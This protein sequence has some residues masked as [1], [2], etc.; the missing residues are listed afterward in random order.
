ML[1]DAVPMEAEE[2][3][4]RYRYWLHRDLAM[5]G[6]VGLVF[7]MLNPSTADA[8]ADDPTIRRCK[9]FGRRWGFRELTVVNLFALRATRPAALV[10][11]GKA[12][13]GERNDDVLR[14]VP[15]DATV[16][17]AWGNHGAHMGRA[18]SVAALLPP[19]LALGHTKSGF[20]RHPLYVRGDAE[21]L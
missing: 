18:A 7:V 5:F 6:R 13:V 11:A 8:V 16:V 2:R 20:P 10:A 14:W 21:P 19:T 4:L 15:R 12:A 1:C 17:A 9:A 3:G